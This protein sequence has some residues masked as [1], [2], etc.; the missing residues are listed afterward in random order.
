MEPTQWNS[1]HSHLF[2]PYVCAEKRQQTRLY[3]NT[4]NT[5]YLLKTSVDFRCSLYPHSSSFYNRD[6][7]VDNASN[8]VTHM[9]LLYIY[10]IFPSKPPNSEYL[11]RTCT[12]WAPSKLRAAPDSIENIEHFFKNVPGS[13]AMQ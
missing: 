9:Q 12:P 4:K 1:H 13:L 6:T 11:H 7:C 8:Q 3:L 5:A 10:D 2:M